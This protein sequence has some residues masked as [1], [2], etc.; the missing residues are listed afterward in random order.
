M[1]F[2]QHLWGEMVPVK[3]VHV[4]SSSKYRLLIYYLKGANTSRENCYC[5]Y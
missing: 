1:S 5:I 4:R 2:S 3:N